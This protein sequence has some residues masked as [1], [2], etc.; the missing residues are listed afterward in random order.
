MLQGRSGHFPRLCG[1]FDESLCHFVSATRFGTWN[2][3]QVN[4]YTS[5]RTARRAYVGRSHSQALLGVVTRVSYDP[6]HR[7]G[8]T[9]HH[10][11]HTS[12]ATARDLDRAL[13]RNFS[14]HA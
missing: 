5:P 3:I 1:R 9:P 4:L 12:Y 14:T 10:T 13:A 2:V 7:T 6:T 11:S 8:V